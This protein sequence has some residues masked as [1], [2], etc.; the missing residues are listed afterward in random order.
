MPGSG[1]TVIAKRLAVRLGKPYLDLDTVI[2][3]RL[4][5]NVPGIKVKYGEAYFRNRES[6]IAREASEQNEGAIIST[7]DGVVLDPKN[8]KALKRTGVCILLK[9]H[10]DTLLRRLGENPLF[11]PLL[12]KEP[13][14]RK[15]FNEMWK[16]REP[17]Y[18]A[19]ADE[20]ID[21]EG[22][23]LDQAVETVVQR[24]HARSDISL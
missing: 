7:G 2:A 1:K 12:N 24:L 15:T 10:V 9:A 11:M 20:T 19:A 13:N 14:P 22:L 3:A 16:V 6:L 4:Y 17:L 23:N 21:T 8:V 18:T 5:S